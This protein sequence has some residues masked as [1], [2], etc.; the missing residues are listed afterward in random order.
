MKKFDQ[1]QDWMQ[2][3][4]LPDDQILALIPRSSDSDFV[5]QNRNKLAEL[6]EI[7]RKIMDLIELER[8]RFNLRTVTDEF[9]KTDFMSSF[10]AVHAKTADK[11]QEFERLLAPY[12]AKLAQVENQVIYS[13]K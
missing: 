6:A 10:A 9:M 8:Q 12:R 13:N 7:N 11:Q 2:K 1:Y 5:S 3:F 4:S